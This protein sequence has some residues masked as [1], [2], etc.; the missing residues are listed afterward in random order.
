MR[1]ASSTWVPPNPSSL[2]RVSGVAQVLQTSNQ[3]ES[4]EAG[5]SRTELSKWDLRVNVQQEAPGCENLSSLRFHSDGDSRAMGESTLTSAQLTP[6]PYR[7]SGPPGRQKSGHRQPHPRPGHTGAL[8]PVT[9]ASRGALTQRPLTPPPGKFSCSEP[10]SKTKGCGEEGA[11][12]APITAASPAR[13]RL[14][15]PLAAG[16]GPRPGQLPGPLSPRGPPVTGAGEAAEGQPGMG[17]PDGSGPPPA[18][19]IPPSGCP[20]PGRPPQGP[21]AASG[22]ARPAHPG[23]KIAFV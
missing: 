15:A 16:R 3:K 2:P 20:R 7:Y 23:E 5:V 6:F 4:Q 18:S 14:F 10:Q 11:A 8:G 9:P 12:E 22:P 13:P 17:K 1:A 21:G 19:S